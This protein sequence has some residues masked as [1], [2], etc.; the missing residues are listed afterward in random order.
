[1]S[2]GHVHL[3]P[4]QDIF[5]VCLPPHAIVTIIYNIF[6]KISEIQ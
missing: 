3:I 6:E 5:T 4:S 1:M 2:Y